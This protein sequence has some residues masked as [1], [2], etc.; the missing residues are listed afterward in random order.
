MIKINHQAFTL[1]ELL[2]VISIIALLIAILLPALGAAR[3][4]ARSIQCASNQRQIGVAMAS[5]QADFK[6]RFPGAAETTSGQQVWPE[7]LNVYFHDTRWNERTVYSR[8]IRDVG[9]ATITCPEARGETNGADFDRPF[10]MN[11]DAMGG[12][13]TVGGGLLAAANDPAGGEY[14][15]TM[16]AGFLDP[17]FLAVRLGADVDAFVRASE[18]V[19][20]RE[21]CLGNDI[22]LQVGDVGLIHMQGARFGGANIP[23]DSAWWGDEGWYSF[24]HNSDT[25]NML[26]IDSHVESITAD[27]GD[28]IDTAEAYEIEP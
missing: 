13:P 25:A 11:R 22:A 9:E 21:S 1:I 18:M 23:T 24:R 15:K 3:G 20:I 12:E 6:G 5:F 10:Q 8:F 19:L 26:F 27:D 16:G 17:A 4:A 28:R 14:G 2:V 7:F